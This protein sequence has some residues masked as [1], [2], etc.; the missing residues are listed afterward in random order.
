MN[1]IAMRQEVREN[2]IRQIEASI[3]L[4]LEKEPDKKID[5]KRIVLSAMANVNIS[6]STAIDYVEVALFNLGLEK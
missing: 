4:A 6:R 5:F 2:K 3:K 1:I